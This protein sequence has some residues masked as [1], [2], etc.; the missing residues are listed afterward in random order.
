MKP[1][2][3]PG[4]IAVVKPCC[5]GDCVM[6]L[7]T[8]DSLETAFPDA[9]RSVLVGRHSRA[10]FEMRD[11]SWSLTAIPDQISP[12]MA[13]KTASAVRSAG[14]DLVILLERS[15]MLR[16]AFSLHFGDRAHSVA[17]LNPEFRHESA[18][19]L[20]V[21]RALGITP[22][23]CRPHLTPS[24]A[25]MARGREVL[26]SYSRPVVLHPG[27]A[28]NPG[29]TMPDKRWPAERYIALARLL[30][31]DGYDV[32]FSG[33]PDDRALNA[34]VAAAADLPAERSLAG[35]LGLMEAAAVAS[36]SGLFVS[37]DTG[38]SHIAA[39]TGAP[40]IAIFGPTNPRRYRPIGHAVTVLAPDASWELPDVDLRHAR[41]S[42]LPQTDAIPVDAVYSAALRMLTTAGVRA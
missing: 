27:G 24:D 42:D 17:S 21:V 36:Q 40:V 26:K 34:H 18:A 13:L 9:E 16:W 29:V 20:D 12:R 28:E 31:D 23:I 38:M 2:G 35:Q 30:T 4:S 32:L 25:D 1:D 19:Y 39:A 7:P 5:I 22:A 33:G 3:T 11:S 37:G 8:L 6:A 41:L 15:R 14:A 10:I